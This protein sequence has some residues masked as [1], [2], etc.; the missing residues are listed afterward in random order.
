M[1]NSILVKEYDNGNNPITKEKCVGKYIG[2]YVEDKCILPQFISVKTGWETPGIL[3]EYINRRL[4]Q[5]NPENH[6]TDDI[7]SII[8]Q[9]ISNVRY[10]AIITETIIKYEN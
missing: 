3:S 1:I 5:I 6:L 4:K 7:E 8:A 9:L 2:Y 10:G